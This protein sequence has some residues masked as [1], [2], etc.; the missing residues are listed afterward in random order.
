MKKIETIVLDNGKILTNHYGKYEPNLTF[1]LPQE[2]N[3]SDFRS[4][5]DGTIDKY[6]DGSIKILSGSFRQNAKG[7]NIFELGLEHPTHI[8]IE[9]DWGGAFNHTRGYLTINKYPEPVYFRRA[10]S[11]GGGSGYTYYIF[12]KTDFEK[13]GKNLTEDDF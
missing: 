8:L 4:T 11:N 1:V 6:F 5:G 2:T 13:I 10:A 12:L 9:C 7:T 3:L